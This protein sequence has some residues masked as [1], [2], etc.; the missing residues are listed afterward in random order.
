MTCELDYRLAAE[1]STAEIGYLSRSESR[2]LSPSTV[3]QGFRRWIIRWQFEQSTA[4]SV[5]G[6]M[7]TAL[8]SGNEDNGIK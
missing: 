1:F 4:K 8:P 3:S 2:P 7:A 6:S 5:A